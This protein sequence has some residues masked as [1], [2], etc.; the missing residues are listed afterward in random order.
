MIFAEPLITIDELT[1][2]YCVFVL[3]HCNGNKSKAA[4]ILGIH[5]RSLYRRL[6]VNGT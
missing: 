5:R 4:V 1:R 6:K 2:A 3:D